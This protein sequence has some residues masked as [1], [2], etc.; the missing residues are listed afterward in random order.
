MDVCTT[1]TTNCKNISQPMVRFHYLDSDKTCCKTP[2]VNT[3]YKFS[4]R[5]FGFS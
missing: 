3:C 2:G 5:V 4:A 1:K